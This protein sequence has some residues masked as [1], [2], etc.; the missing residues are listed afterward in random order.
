MKIFKAGNLIVLP[1]S[2]RF[3]VWFA[4]SFISK[5][6]HNILKFFKA[7]NLTFL[8][9]SSR[10]V[11]S[12]SSASVLSFREISR[13]SALS[14]ASDASFLILEYHDISVSLNWQF[15]KLTTGQYIQR[16][17]T[18]IAGILQ[19]LRNSL[20]HAKLIFLHKSV[21]PSHEL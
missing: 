16:K 8:S 1:N 11:V 6:L 4:K 19:H 2:S 12:C 14:L 5:L 10:F 17:Q 7:G 15:V 18:Q 20:R 21:D 3:V 9:S 13:F